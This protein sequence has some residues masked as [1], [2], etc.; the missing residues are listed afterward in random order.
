MESSTA[1]HHAGESCKH[2]GF[3]GSKGSIDRLRLLYQ[4]EWML[5]FVKPQIVR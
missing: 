3:Q 4:K 1:M 2:G 5:T